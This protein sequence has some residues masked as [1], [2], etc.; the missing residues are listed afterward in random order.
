MI[1]IGNLHSS[2]SQHSAYHNALTPRLEQ[3]LQGI[4]RE[5]AS[6]HPVRVHLPVTVEVMDSIYAV[7]SKNPNQYQEI[8]L[9][10]ACCIAFFGFLNVGEMTVPTKMAYDPSIHRSLEDVALDRRSTATMIWLT[11][12]QSKTDP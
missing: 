7:L 10:A 12:K 1:S 11:I 9:W 5:Q 4:N 2:S 3:I 8:M 6:T